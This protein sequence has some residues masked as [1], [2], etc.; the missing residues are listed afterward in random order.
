MAFELTIKRFKPILAKCLDTITGAEKIVEHMIVAEMITMVDVPMIE[1]VTT[2]T[3]I[4]EVA[5]T[6]IVVVAG[7]VIVADLV[8]QDVIEVIIE[9]RKP[10]PIEKETF[11]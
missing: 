10:K 1:V 6:V 9:L 3:E 2:M 4:V 8:L 5:E 11:S 7:T